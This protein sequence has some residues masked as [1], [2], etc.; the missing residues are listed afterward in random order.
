M[1]EKLAKEVLLGHMV[2]PFVFP[3]IAGLRV[4]PLGLVPMNKPNKLQLIHHLSDPAVLGWVRHY[5]LG[6][7]LAKRTLKQHFA[8]CPFTLVIF[9][10]LVAFVRIVFA[11][12]VAFLWVSP[13]HELILKSLVHF[14]SGWSAVRLRF[15]PCYITWMIFCLLGRR[16]HG[17]VLPSCIP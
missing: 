13:F 8:F 10:I 11:L 14:L 7:L 12:I 17:C 9:S 5:G 2:G 1:A 16:G 4:S 15:H 6:A 3:P